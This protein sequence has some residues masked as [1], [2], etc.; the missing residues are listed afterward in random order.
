MKVCTY[1]LLICFLFNCKSAEED[2]ARIK[3]YSDNVGDIPFD[4]N[5]DN[6]S[7]MFCDSTKVIS[8]RSTLT[9]SDNGNTVA[10]VCLKNFKF[11]S[12]YEPFSGY[13]I[14]RFIVNCKKE[15][16]R[17]RIQT[18]DKNFSLK[19]CPIGLQNHLMSIVKELKSW[20]NS[21]SRGKG[22]DRSKF[23]NFKITDGKIE[24]VLQ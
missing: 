7:F 20:E 13:V 22:F 4:S 23:V 15:T 14:V 9:F 5:T 16:G 17:F 10:E 2:T 19:E 6:R 3:S 8:G 1:I 24:K 12:T 18:L 11:R 21:G